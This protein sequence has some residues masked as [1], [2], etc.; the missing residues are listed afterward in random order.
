MTSNIDKFTSKYPNLII[1]NY[2]IDKLRTINKSNTKRI[3]GYIKLNFEEEQII[4]P[5]K[6]SKFHNSKNSIINDYCSAIIK[7][8]Y[9]IDNKKLKVGDI[10]FSYEDYVISD[11]LKL[12]Y[13]KELE[14]SNHSIIVYPILLDEKNSIVEFDK[15]SYSNTFNIFTHS[16][17]ENK[18]M[19]EYL[20]DVYLFCEDNGFID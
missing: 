16:H 10:I 6:H 14:K 3:E 13:F 12:F 18:N 5:I 20:L 7:D 19:K 9:L 11:R 15:N 17:L 4:I 1:H 2:S 8:K